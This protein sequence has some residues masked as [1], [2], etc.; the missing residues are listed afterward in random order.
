MDKCTIWFAST[1]EISYL[2]SCSWLLQGNSRHRPPSCS[3]KKPRHQPRLYFPPHIQSIT[4]S[5]PFHLLYLSHNFHFF[6]VPTVFPLVRTTI[7]P[8]LG[9][10]NCLLT[11]IPTSSPAPF[12][13]ILHAPVVCSWSPLSTTMTGTGGDSDIQ[14][15]SV[16]FLWVRDN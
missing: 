14:R 12:Q 11:S 10:C 2:P 6:S 3:E 9:S 15:T 8:G 7:F 1:L 13:F 16:V 5:Y 4:M